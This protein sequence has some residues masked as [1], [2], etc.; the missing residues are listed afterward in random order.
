MIVSSFCGCCS[1]LPGQI[2]GSLT[3]DGGHQSEQ[4]VL[5][6]LLNYKREHTLSYL[7][8]QRFWFKTLWQGCAFQKGWFF[9]KVSNSLGPPPH[10]P[11]FPIFVEEHI[12]GNSGDTLIFAHFGIVSWSNICTI[13]RKGPFGEQILTFHKGTFEIF[14]PL[15]SEL[16]VEKMSEIILQ[17]SLCVFSF[18]LV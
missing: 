11:P 12:L 6:G 10:P 16:C 8:Y 2:I 7:V 18:L 9:R 5:S 13:I 4:Q 3:A 17:L 1:Y 14:Q 15:G